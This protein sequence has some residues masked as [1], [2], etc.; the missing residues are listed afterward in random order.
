VK[1]NFQRHH[2]VDD[3]AKR[4][5]IDRLPMFDAIN[6][7]ADFTQT[8]TNNKNGTNLCYRH[9]FSR[10]QLCVVCAK[11]AFRNV[12][13][14]RVESA[15]PIVVTGSAYQVCRSNQRQPLRA[16]MN[17]THTTNKRT[18]L[19]N[20]SDNAVRYMSEGVYRSQS[21]RSAVAKPLSAASADVERRKTRDETSKH[22]NKRERPIR[23]ISRKHN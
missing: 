19:V 3:H 22:D 20:T 11:N 13:S 18:G 15:K 9:R 6:S 10:L 2:L 21:S 23:G 16:R 4:P 1:R 12:Q 8:R 14:E 5:H 7:R 17:A